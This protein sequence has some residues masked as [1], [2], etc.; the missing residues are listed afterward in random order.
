MPASNR[1][2]VR[3]CVV[4]PPQP[5]WFF[6]SSNTFSASARSRYSCPS[7]RI[8]LSSEV[9][10][11]PRRK[12]EPHFVT[13][14]RREWLAGH[15]PL[16]RLGEGAVEVGDEGFDARLQVLLRG[17]AGAAQQLAHEDGEP[18]LDLVQPG[19]MLGGEVK[20]DA[21]AGIAQERLTTGH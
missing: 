21:V 10:S 4:K 6:S 15:G 20:A 18:D 8:S 14:S 1:Q 3:S 5:H 2:R 11:T 12:N 17:E 13:C 9:T 16:E 19:R 7:V